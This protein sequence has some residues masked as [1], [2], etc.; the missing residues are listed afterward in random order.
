MWVLEKK[1]N[2]DKEKQQENKCYIC[3]CIFHSV[4]IIIAVNYLVLS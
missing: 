3:G 1:E 2:G 4:L